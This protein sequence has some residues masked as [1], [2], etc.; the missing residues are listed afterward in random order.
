MIYYCMG[1]QI[2]LETI[3]GSCSRLRSVHSYVD[4]TTF[5]GRPEDLIRAAPFI[6]AELGCAGLKVR[7]MNLYSRQ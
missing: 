1:K 4:N 7:Y 6:I 2:L 3:M 5:I